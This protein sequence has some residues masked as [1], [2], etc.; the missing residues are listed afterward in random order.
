LGAQLAGLLAKASE[1]K[2]VERRVVELSRL[3]M[4]ALEAPARS[5]SQR[6]ERSS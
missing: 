4:I 6:S 2:V 5:G 3:G 1:K